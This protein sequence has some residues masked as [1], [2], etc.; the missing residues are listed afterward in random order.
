MNSAFPSLSVY[1]TG[2]YGLLDPLQQF[3]LSHQ[4]HPLQTLYISVVLP[5]IP[6]KKSDMYSVTLKLI[7]QLIKQK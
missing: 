5:W 7:L 2:F 4:S 1:T 3:F 6:S